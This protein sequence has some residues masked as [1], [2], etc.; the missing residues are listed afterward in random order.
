[1]TTLKRGS[2]FCLYT[3]VPMVLLAL[4]AVGVI[5]VRLRHGPISFDVVVGPIE[6]GIN[7]ELSDNQVKI[8]GAE[9][10]LGS[11]GGLDFRLRNMSVLEANGD[12]VAVAP[13]AAVSVSSAAL[14]R[15]QVVPERIELIDP[16]INLVFTDEGG[17]ELRLAHDPKLANPRSDARVNGS[18]AP[19]V[20][21]SAGTDKAEP[22][23]LPRLLSEASRRA[24]KRLDASS[25]LTEFGVRNA[26]VVLEYAGQRSSWRVPEVNVDFNHGRK[27]SVISGRATVESPRGPWAVSFLTDESERTDTLIVKTTVRDLVPST[28]SAAAPPLALLKMLDM[29][30]SGDATLQLSTSGE[31]DKAEIALEVGDGRIAIPGVTGDP[32]DL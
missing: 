17:I 27:R 30:V 26:T 5:F 6:R 10:S 18:P 15:L 8:G 4:I 9:L 3:A 24:R 11:N 25:Y 21:P 13:L 12:V 20:A 2:K 22:L 14:W 31:I 32:F 1:M 29:R 28:L 7:A 23:N 19:P 16:E